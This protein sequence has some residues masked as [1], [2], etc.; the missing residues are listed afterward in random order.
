MSHSVSARRRVPQLADVSVNLDEDHGPGA[1]LAEAKAG[2]CFGLSN[3]KFPGPVADVSHSSS[4]LSYAR[5]IWSS[6]IC[7][8]TYS[9]L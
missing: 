6:L 8:C 9:T 2:G 5:C 3:Y 1:N 4:C 7:A